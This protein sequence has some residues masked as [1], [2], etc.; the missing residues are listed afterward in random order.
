MEN[1]TIARED[2]TNVEGKYVNGEIGSRH[3]AWG[4][5]SGNWLAGVE[6]GG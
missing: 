5:H 3:S 6:R 2:L 1:A 4:Y